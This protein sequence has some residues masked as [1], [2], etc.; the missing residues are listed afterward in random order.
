MGLQRNVVDGWARSLTVLTASA[1]LTLTACATQHDSVERELERLRSELAALQAQAPSPQLAAAPPHM[2]APTAAPLAHGP[3]PTYRAVAPGP[4]AARAPAPSAP[5]PLPVVKLDPLR[6]GEPTIR[7]GKAGRVA[8]PASTRSADS[9]L[10]Y[11]HVDAHGNLVDY[12]GN[13]VYHA[14]TDSPMIDTVADPE[15]T[16][17][18]YEDPHESPRAKVARGTAVPS[19]MPS[20]DTRWE[21]EPASPGV[22]SLD[23]G[24]VVVAPPPGVYEIEEPRLRQF[25]I[26]DHG[27]PTERG[28]IHVDGERAFDEQAPINVGARPAAQ[29]APAPEW[30]SPPAGPVAA[31]P[32]EPTWAP[33]AAPAPAPAPAPNVSAPPAVVPRVPSSYQPPRR[34]PGKSNVAVQRTYKGS[35]ERKV[36]KLYTSAMSKFN[37][38]EMAAAAKSFELLLQRHADHELADNALYWLAETAYANADWLQ[39][40]TWFQDVILR[41]PAGNKLPDAMLKSALCYAKLGDTSY[42]LQMLTEVETLFATAPVAKI[43]RERRLALADAGGGG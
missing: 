30:A 16:D 37:G 13:I 2:R 41:Y 9:P 25:D 20:Q 35:A 8:P 5:P 3:A 15:P 33:T 32:T 21:R 12:Q 7:I 24:R 27:Y 28:G 1:A 29:P 6:E 23:D 31:A 34:A 43:A 38:G 11:H 4:P 26:Q 36:Q 17:R 42:A 40:L 18:L 22:R 10:E 39:A 14:G 19:V